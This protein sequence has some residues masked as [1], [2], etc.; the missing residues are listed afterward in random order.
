MFY[1][2]EAHGLAG[3]IVLEMDKVNLGKLVRDLR[4][5]AG[6]S[7]RVLSANSGV[8]YATLQGIEDGDSNP[9]VDTLTSLAGA[10]GL[11]FEQLVFRVWELSKSQYLKNLKEAVWLKLNEDPVQRQYFLSIIFA[12]KSYL[13]PEAMADALAELRRQP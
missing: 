9:T 12:D 11:T 8:A 5:T 4:K 3:E 10:L 7:Q 13:S 6:F 2:V 1:R